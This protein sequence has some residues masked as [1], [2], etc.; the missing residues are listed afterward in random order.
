MFKIALFAAIVGI[1]SHANAAFVLQPNK[2]YISSD[3][4]VLQYSES[5]NYEATASGVSS[6]EGLLGSGISPGGQFYVGMRASLVYVLNKSGQLVRTIPFDSGGGGRTT[7][8][9]FDAQGRGYFTDIGGLFEI[10]PALTTVRHVYDNTTRHSGI[11]IAPNGDLFAARQNT[12]EIVR[13]NADRVPTT[14]YH[15]G[16]VP[17]GMDFSPDGNL[18]YVDTPYNNGSN[19]LGRLVRLNIDTGQQTVLYDKLQVAVDIEFLRDGSFYLSYDTGGAVQK[20]NANFQPVGP[21]RSIGLLGDAINFLEVSEVPEPAFPAGLTFLA[22]YNATRKRSASHHRL[23]PHPAETV[24]AINDC[25][26][27]FNNR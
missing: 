4:G 10:N 7:N 14:V 5:L 15:T 26:L 22:I 24:L 19:Y 3:I 12:D 18:Y 11:A 21:A 9:V 6:L 17:M 16:R 1:T 25:A 27:H 8:V 23:L 13:F 20:Y 2:L